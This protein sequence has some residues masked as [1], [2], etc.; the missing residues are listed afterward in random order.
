MIEENKILE[1]EQRI[2]EYFG[3]SIE[4]VLGRGR[5]SAVILA[6]H[7]IIY[8]LH[9]DY[10]VCRRFLMQRY[11]RKLRVIPYICANLRFLIHN[12]KRYKSYYEEIK[13]D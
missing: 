2:C 3:V 4:E 1:I 5:K 11:N 13:Q 8:I 7:F 9:C 6:R 12:D 10:N